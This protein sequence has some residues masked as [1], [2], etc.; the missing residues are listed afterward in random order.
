ML[1]FDDALMYALRQ[2]LG[3]INNPLRPVR[4]H[5]EKFIRVHR[6]LFE[7]GRIVTRN[8]RDFTKY[9]FLFETVVAQDSGS[10]AIPFQK[11]EKN[12]FR[13]D[14]VE[15]ESRRTQIRSV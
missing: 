6:C 2:E 15:A 10:G 5:R 14:V 1:G 3:Q 13:A 7:L 11:R 12:L 9:V 4:A 8:F